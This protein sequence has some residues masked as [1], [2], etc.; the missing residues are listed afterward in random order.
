M[1]PVKAYVDLASLREVVSHLAAI[2]RPSASL[3][4]REAAE[5][6]AARLRDEGCIAGVEREQAHGGYWWPV[7]IISLVAALAGMLSL[8]GSR[9]I[10]LVGG[11]LAAAAIA[12]DIDSGHHVVRHAFL[13][14]RPTWTVLAETGDPDAERTLVILAHHDAAHSG[15]VFHPGPLNF[16]YSHFPD[17][18]EKSNEG[19][20]FW[21]PVFG[22][23]LLVAVGSLLRLR[24]LVRLGTFLSLGSA[25]AMLDIG[26]REVVPGAN[27]NLSAV[28]VQIEVA[29]ALR[30]RTVKG[31]RVLLVSAGS[32]ESLQEGILAFGR[33]HFHELP[34]DRTWFLNLDTVGSPILYMVEG[35][36]V[37]KMRDYDADFKDLV[38]AA[39][40]DAGVALRRGV[41]ARA[42]TDTVVPVKAGYPSALLVSLTKS[43]ALAN[44]HWP[45]DTAANVDY[46][47]VG[48]AARVTEAV[49]RRLAA[50]PT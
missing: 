50:R 48:D 21:F 14:Y 33:R 4:E 16:I 26:R 25:A 17:Y 19:V 45:T 18:I 42:S 23:P 9:L 29:R 5:W 44:Y 40:A 43:K 35:E 20:P 15:L 1:E 10:G 6:I 39:A 3:G 13:P 27:D 32:E 30:A 49:V 38:M 11:S 46:D 47:T 24:F 36:G 2:R 28:A 8:L 22:G 12:D 41:R 7:G 37:L 34:L 31:L